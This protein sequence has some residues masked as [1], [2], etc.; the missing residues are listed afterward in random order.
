MPAPFTSALMP[1]CV[2]LGKDMIVGMKYHLP[3]VY[4][5]SFSNA[6]N[7]LAAIEDLVFNTHYISLPDLVDA[8]RS[9]YGGEEALLARIQCAP[10]WGTDD[11]HADRWAVVLIAIRERVLDT[12]DVQFSS[13]PH[14][15]CHVIRSLHYFT[16]RR[17]GASPDGRLAGTPVADSI[18]A[19]M[20]TAMQGP[21]GVLNSVAKL[22][23]AQNYRGGTNPFHRVGRKYRLRV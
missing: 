16:G 14:T 5:R 22:D 23:A 1:N 18:G 10:K 11:A 13:G 6:V 2:R 17:I 19:E 12:V 20:G 9:N 8:L 21:T 7:A 15:V 4:E 3:G